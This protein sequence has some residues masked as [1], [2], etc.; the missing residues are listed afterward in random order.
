VFLGLSAAGAPART[1]ATCG[2]AT[3]LAACR[4][5][6]P[7]IMPELAV[8]PPDAMIVPGDGDFPIKSTM[9][10]AFPFS[11]VRSTA[12]LPPSMKK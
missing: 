10:Y 2:Q 5:L 9:C 8:A 7:E 1:V 11:V 6:T 3:D 12:A 4:Q